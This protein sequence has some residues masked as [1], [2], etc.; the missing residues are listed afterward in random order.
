[1]THLYLTRRLIQNQQVD[2]LMS[3]AAST[4]IVPAPILARLGS[5]VNGSASIATSIYSGDNNVEA[6]EML[7]EAYFMQ[8]DGTRNKILSVCP[9]SY[10][11]GDRLSCSCL[12][13][14]YIIKKIYLYG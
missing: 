12:L 9:F 13:I 6:L 2:A 3:S 11:N 8:L 5:I 10:T 14:A 4:A 1:M 7:L